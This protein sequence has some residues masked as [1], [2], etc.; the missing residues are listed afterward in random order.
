MRALLL[1]L[2]GLGV[3]ATPDAAHFDSLEANTLGHLYQCIPSLE[4]PALESLGLKEIL[5][6]CDSSPPSAGGI[7]GLT[8]AYGRMRPRSLGNE[9]IVGHWEMAGVIT[10]QALATFPQFP[11]EL[12]RAIEA[13]ADITFIG[14]D[15]SS[16]ADVLHAFGE[17]HLLTGHPILYTTASSALQIAGHEAV[18]PRTRLYQIARIA[19]RHCDQWR[20]GRVIARPFSGSGGIWSEAPGRHDYTMAPPHT[21]LNSI[22]ETGIPVEGIGKIGDI[23]AQSGVTRAHRTTSNA[24]AQK[25]IE[26]LWHSPNDAFLF[27][28]LPDLDTH[29]GHRRDPLGYADALMRFDTWLADFLIAVE[30]EDLIIIT[31][32]HGNDPT[33]RGTDHT[34]EEVPL[35]VIHHDQTGPLGVRDTFADVAA[36][37][38]HY[39]RVPLIDPLQGTSV[40][41]L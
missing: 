7:T 14:N 25:V 37:L 30:P 35:L 5:T 39:F 27:A 22:A 32:D 38:A 40:L 17:E 13:E 15:L 2:D 19:R 11:E 41:H 36:S 8:G 6:G 34:R 28:N 26:E 29:F 21:V 18:I 10:E 9:T 16:T 12:V 1:V 20:I 3:G 4:L 24:E 23:F 33:F 31:S